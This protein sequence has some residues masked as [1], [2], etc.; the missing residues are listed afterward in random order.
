V[1][2]RFPAGVTSWPVIS[3]DVPAFASSG[4]AADANDDSYDTSWR[5]DTTS[6]W[7]AYDLSA[8]PAAERGKVLVVW[9]NSSYNYDHTLINDYSYNMPGDYT[10]D[11]NPAPGGGDP[12][13]MGWVTRVTVKGNHCH[14]RRHVIDM[15]GDNWIRINVTAVDGAPAMAIGRS[16][17]I[18]SWI[19]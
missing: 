7:L 12:P 3:R 6:A 16:I 9:Y 8:V 5:A 17:N 19:G 13:A 4:T 1:I 15:T 11:V 10:I 2:T 18:A 14:S